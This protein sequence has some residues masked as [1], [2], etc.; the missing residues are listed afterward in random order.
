[1]TLRINIV[2]LLFL[3]ALV[4]MGRSQ[5]YPPYYPGSPYYVAPP[6]PPPPPVQILPQY[7]QPFPV[8]QMPALVVPSEPPGY[9]GQ[10]QDLYPASPY[11]DQ[12]GADDD[13]GE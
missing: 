12:G 11:N 10:Q 1:M 6:P 8:P 13:S 3:M 5:E 4:G 7:R 9:N 2:A